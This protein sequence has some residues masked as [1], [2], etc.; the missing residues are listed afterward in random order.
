ME[1]S[2]RFG[3]CV[4]A[5]SFVGFQFCFSA[6][7]PR[8]SL[9]LCPPYCALPPARR[10]EWDS[11]C[12][13]T[14]HALLVGSFCLYILWYDAAVNADPIWGDPRLVKL[15]VAI[16]SGYLLYDLLLLG[17]YWKTMGDALFVCHH[18]A[19]LYAYGYVLNRGVLPYFANFRL[20]SELSTPFVNLRW[21]LEAAGWP[22]G[23]GPVR[24][25]GVA[26][27][28]AF[29]SVRIAVIP[30]Y[31]ARVLAWHGT[32]EYAR[33]GPAVQAAWIGPS[34]ALEVLNLVWMYRILRGVYRA[35]HAPRKQL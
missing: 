2:T 30:T 19:A 29:F 23:S 18:V 3:Y 25:N 6:V 33:L 11:R 21:F 7:S 8:L 5:A 4:V 20:L 15:N 31:Y 12:V 10:I 34:L 26:M 13:S 14:L 27:A 1:D 35:C 16:I 9:A 32:P 17:R 22:R 24:A 28:V